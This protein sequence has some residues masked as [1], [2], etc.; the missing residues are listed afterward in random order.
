[1]LTLVSWQKSLLKKEALKFPVNKTFSYFSQNSFPALG[2][3]STKKDKKIKIKF[4]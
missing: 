2:R 4:V 1:L 3:F